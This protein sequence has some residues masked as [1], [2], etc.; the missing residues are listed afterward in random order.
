MKDFLG[1]GLNV[2]L[3]VDI[4]KNNDLI[5]ALGIFLGLVPPLHFALL[6]QLQLNRIVCVLFACHFQI[7]GLVRTLHWES[8]SI[9]VVQY[10]FSS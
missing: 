9:M 10:L 8:N 3:I 4:F 5:E 2:K 7:N 6:K 1:F